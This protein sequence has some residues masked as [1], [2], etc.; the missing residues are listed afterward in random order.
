MESIRVTKTTRRIKR[1]VDVYQ[2]SESLSFFIDVMKRTFE[3]PE[4]YFLNPF[5]DA[6]PREMVV[7]IMGTVLEDNMREEPMVFFRTRARL[8][9]TDVLFRDLAACA[10]REG[11]QHW[12][13]A[14]APWW[15]DIIFLDLALSVAIVDENWLME[16]LSK[17]MFI[18]HF[19]STVWKI[20]LLKLCLKWNYGKI[21]ML[22]FNV[23]MSQCR[24]SLEFLFKMA[25]KY[26]RPSETELIVTYC[27]LLGYNPIDRFT[28]DEVHLTYM[29][30]SNGRQ[31]LNA[32]I[33]T[34]LDN[35][36]CWVLSCLKPCIAIEIS[37]KPLFLGLDKH[38]DTVREIYERIC[39]SIENM[40]I[41]YPKIIIQ[42]LE[43]I[44]Q[45]R[46]QCRLDQVISLT[47]Q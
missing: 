35:F 30:A 1:D 12:L 14:G 33:E 25:L 20:A 5:H 9:A 31:I 45:A 23:M 3:K 32:M 7:K 2:S 36:G 24:E 37:F 16:R 11:R 27:D 22:K 40:A 42:P 41:V 18:S 38:H 10:V 46:Q 29:R 8:M 43:S 15:A 4:E 39:A 47:H 19:Y 44:L 26:R 21:F 28:I 13:R 6:L 17:K 34:P